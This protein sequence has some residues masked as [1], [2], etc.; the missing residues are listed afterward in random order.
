MGN[1]EFLESDTKKTLSHEGPSKK[2]QLS[3]WVQSTRMRS[4]SFL[5]D[6]NSAEY[7]ELGCIKFNSGFSVYKSSV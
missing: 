1:R 7:S 6:T 5:M 4:I 3:V 2:G